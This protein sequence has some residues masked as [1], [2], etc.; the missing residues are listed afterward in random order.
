MLAM[1]LGENCLNFREKST[2]S[3]FFDDLATKCLMQ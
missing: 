2:L 1:I 3:E